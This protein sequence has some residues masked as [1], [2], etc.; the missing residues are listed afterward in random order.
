[1]EESG[2]L[3]ATI[4][5]MTA[6]ALKVSQANDRV[7]EQWK[8]ANVHIQKVGNSERNALAAE[9]KR[10]RGKPVRPDGSAVEVASCPGPTDNGVSEKFVSLAEYESLQSRAGDDALQVTLLQDYINGVCLVRAADASD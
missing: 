7:V 10:V 3:Q 6:T 4:S 9:L 2:G 8:L 1:M 5:I